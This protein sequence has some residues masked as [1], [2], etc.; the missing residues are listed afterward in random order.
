MLP[1]NE[2]WIT[3]WCDMQEY[4]R[5]LYRAP[6]VVPGNGPVIADGAVL[7]EDGLVAA[8]GSYADLKGLDAQLEDYD[9]HVITPALVNCHAHLELSHL[10]GLAALAGDSPTPGD[11]TGWIRALLAARAENPDQETVHDAARMALARLYAG[12]CRAVADIG[13]R[14]ESRLLGEGFKTEVLFFLELLG[15][16]GESEESA[17]AAL[18][19]I[20]GALRCTAH[21]SYSAGPAL[22]RAL[23]ERTRAGKSLFS[24]HVA[25]SVQE[26][27]FLRTGGGP[28]RDFLGERG[29][30]VA[31]FTAP[32]MGAVRYLDSLGVLDEQTLC[33]HAVHVEDEEISLLAARG[34][35]VCLCP[36]SNRF[37]GVG[38]APVQKMLAHGIPLVLGTDSLASNPHL[39]LWR[40]MQVLREDHPDIPPEAVFA[41]ASVN[42]ARLLG[43]GGKLGSVAPGVSSSLPAV[44]CPAKN[45]AEV[46]EYLTS[47]GT[48]IQ[49]EWLE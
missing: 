12:G 14:P 10:A 18:S 49:L 7:T 11:M 21:A 25:E 28:F 29:V 17:L 36:G 34:A 6:Y 16:C 30:E 40:E 27:E 2:E 37:M 24:M 1:G 44:R 9:G 43:I 48:D 35:A 19:G 3:P 22:I 26:I 4:P 41:M 32:G 15:L 20:G 45:E 13:N 46:F 38:A 31:A 47:T 23:K 33:V 42:G 8:V 5:Y 39:S